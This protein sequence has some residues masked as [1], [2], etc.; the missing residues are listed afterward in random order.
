MQEAN[1]KKKKNVLS[2]P[3]I[4]FKV[5]SIRR[6]NGNEKKRVEQ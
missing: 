5:P 2:V 4:P 6:W 1:Q 3:D